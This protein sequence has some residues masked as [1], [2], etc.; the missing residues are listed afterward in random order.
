MVTVQQTQ[1]LNHFQISKSPW[2]DLTIKP[3]PSLDVLDICWVGRLPREVHSTHPHRQNTPVYFHNATR[4]MLSIR[5]IFL[6][7]NSQ[8]LSTGALYV[9]SAITDYDSRIGYVDNDLQI[10]IQ[11]Q[12][13]RIRMAK[14]EHKYWKMQQGNTSLERELKE[15]NS[16]ADLQIQI[17]NLDNVEDMNS[18]VLNSSETSS[19]NSSPSLKTSPMTIFKISSQTIIPW[20]SLP[21]NATWNKI[22]MLPSL[23]ASLSANLNTEGQGGS[24]DL[25]LNFLGTT[26]T[27]QYIIQIQLTKFRDCAFANVLPN[28]MTESTTVSKHCCRQR[29]VKIQFVPCT[30]TIFVQIPYICWGC[31]IKFSYTNTEPW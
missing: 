30:I 20:Q 4:K 8:S 29:G 21:L 9:T 16:T 25:D 28:P 24:E 18:F 19:K 7:F 11:I 15:H 27:Q 31:L 17:Q 14:D 1:L 6:Q 2:L 13:T 22:F 10:Q 23:P 5:N 3:S 26:P 12:L